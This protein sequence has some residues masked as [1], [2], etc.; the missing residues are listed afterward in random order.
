[1]CR[2]GES[3]WRGRAGEVDNDVNASGIDFRVGMLPA[4][5]CSQTRSERCHVVTWSGGGGGVGPLRCVVPRRA[6][7]C[8]RHGSPHPGCCA[9]HPEALLQPCLVEWLGQHRIE[10]PA[11]VRLDIPRRAVAYVQATDEETGATHN[12]A[13][14]SRE[15]L[16]LQLPR[17]QQV[18]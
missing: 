9:V 17:T 11:Q 18:L 8:A 14:R 1:M 12:S 2:M 3:V 16:Q 7:Q 15:A 6:R 10:S 13:C 5:R 4:H